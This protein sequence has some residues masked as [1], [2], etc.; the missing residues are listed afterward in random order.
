MTDT[1]HPTCKTH[2]CEIIVKD[3]YDGYCLRCF[4]H[5]FP[6]KPISRNYKT[7]EFS[8]IEYIL[9]QFPDLSWYSDKKIEE[10]CSKKRPD[11]LLDLGYQI[12]IIEIDEN[13]HKSYDCSCE[14]KRLMTLSQDVNFRP[15]IFIRFNPDDYFDEK[16]EKI[17]SCWNITKKTG[18]CKI[19]NNKEW[20]IRLDC[21]VEQIKYWIHPDNKTDKTVE[22]IELYYNKNVKL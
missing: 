21:L 15:I 18:I 2:L 14:N 22:V 12:I 1:T 13:Q 7:K 4:M 17:N 16:G 11:L 20:N 6:D 19:K 10:G 3:K 5:L 9:Q 8:V